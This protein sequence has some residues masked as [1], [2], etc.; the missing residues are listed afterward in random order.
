MGVYVMNVWIS[1]YPKIPQDVCINKHFNIIDITNYGTCDTI[2]LEKIK[3][4]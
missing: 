1:Y 4:K 2:V 3:I